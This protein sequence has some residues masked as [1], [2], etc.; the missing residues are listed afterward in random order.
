[1]FNFFDIS[2]SIYLKHQFLCHSLIYR[3]ENELIEFF[4]GQL[5][6]WVHYIPVDKS[7][8]NL[9]DLNEIIEFA[10]ENDE[11]SSKIAQK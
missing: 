7:H 5:I 10:I 6:P 4:H 1:M 3:V 11:I 9:K 8:N 2:T